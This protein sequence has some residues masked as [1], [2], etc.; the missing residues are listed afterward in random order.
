MPM[1]F[2]SC[3]FTFFIIICR[4]HGLTVKIIY[5]MLLNVN[6]DRNVRSAED[7]MIVCAII[8]DK[9]IMNRYNVIKP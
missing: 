2:F 5:E 1:L 6:N 4:P 3:F 7:H 8:I 9:R